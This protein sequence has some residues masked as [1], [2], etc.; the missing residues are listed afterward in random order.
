MRLIAAV[1]CALAILVPA[2]RTP[3]QAAEQRPAQ[4]ETET[5]APASLPEV[6]KADFKELCNGHVTGA[7]G[8]DGRPGPHILWTAYSSRATTPE[9]AKRLTAK[10]AG[11][12]HETHESCDLWRF[13]DKAHPIWD[14]CPVAVKGPASECAAPPAGTK[15][16]LIVSTMVGEY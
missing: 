11:V 10:L 15:S 6:P 2:S 12:T 5:A 16:I 1:S 9:L 14:L 3:A 13:D 7:P 4:H 8:A